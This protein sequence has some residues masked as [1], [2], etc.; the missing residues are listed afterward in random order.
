M[1]LVESK[2]RLVCSVHQACAASY[3]ESPVATS[4]S[5]LTNYDEE[6]TMIL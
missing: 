6:G 2:L 3:S 1:W 5:G 4:P